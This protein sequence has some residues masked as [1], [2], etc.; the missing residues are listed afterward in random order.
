MGQVA[1][2]VAPGIGGYSRLLSPRIARRGSVSH[3]LPRGIGRNFASAR[4]R[5][6][7]GSPTLTSSAAPLSEPV[8]GIVSAGTQSARLQHPSVYGCENLDV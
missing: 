5:L 6:S 1:V 7:S 4:R 2:R 3:A 8:F